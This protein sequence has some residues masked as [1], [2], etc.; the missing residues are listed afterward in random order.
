MKAVICGA[1]IGGLA[2]AQRLDTIG[3]DVVVL[4][5]SPGPR[6][7]GYMI[8]FFGP[9]FD[10]A[11]AMGVLPRL[12]EVGYVVT[13][14]TYRDQ[15]GRRRA[16]LGFDQFA[17]V[18]DGRLISIMR[19][20]L[21]RSL[22]EHLSDR[23]DLRYGAALT[24]VE[25]HPDSVRVTVDGATLEADLLVGADGIH[26]TVRG[27][28]FG[29]E[30]DFLRH[31][32]FHTAAWIFTDPEVRAEVA[33][34]LT[35]TDTMTRQLGFYAL[36]GDQV[37]VFA[38]H[39]TDDPTLP[40]DPRERV[41]QEYASLGWLAPRALAACPPAAQMYY[42]QVAQVELP[43]WSRDRVTLIGDACQAVSVVA[44]QGASLAIAGAYVLADRLSTAPSIDS[45]LAEY[46]RVLRPVVADKQQVARKGV[47][48][49]VP[50]ARWQLV[51]RRAALHLARLPLLDRY[52]MAAV[53][54]KQSAIIS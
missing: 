52:V 28:V 29:E 9:G 3:W 47:R 11:E 2:L 33:G 26:S 4:E 43:R 39:R 25:N 14:M 36:R 30:R 5:R 22:R 40:A 23:V 6:T 32:G 20:D 34:Q 48:W 19:P 35:L 16:G 7:Q 1:G 8:D 38:V 46:E 21:E 17:K 49:F 42:D 12:R 10:A 51:A 41:R 15:E 13:E 53:A 31:L 44:G 18:V 50:E 27:L 24:G 37:A 45:A 54:G